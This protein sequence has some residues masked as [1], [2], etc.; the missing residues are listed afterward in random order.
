MPRPSGAFLL[1]D[2][3]WA[4]ARQFAGSSRQFVNIAFSMRAYKV[5]ACLILLAA[6]AIAQSGEQQIVGRWNA[7]LTP[8]D[9]AGVKLYDV[10]FEFVV[11]RN[12]AALNAALYN[13]PERMNF[14]SAQFADGVLTLRLAHY[15]GVITA[16][17]Q[18]QAA[19][20]TATT[21]GKPAPGSGTIPSMRLNG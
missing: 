16:K 12:G 9:K 20:W 11:E 4:S 5:I 21:R 15:D 1:P 8:L 7:T 17:A 18:R 19:I 13:G 6:F 10:A 3:R 14:T 2:P